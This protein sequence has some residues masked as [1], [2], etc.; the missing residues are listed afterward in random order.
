MTKGFT[1]TFTF[2]FTNPEPRSPRSSQTPIQTT[3]PPSPPKTLQDNSE[4]TEID[5][6][7]IHNDDTFQTEQGD[8]DDSNSILK[9][10]ILNVI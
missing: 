7:N 9:D 6:G 5:S 1:F 10:E 3:R 4:A 8:E 2:T